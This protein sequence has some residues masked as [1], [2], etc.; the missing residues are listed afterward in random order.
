MHHCFRVLLLLI[1]SLILSGS[2]IISGA[3]EQ[4]KFAEQGSVDFVVSDSSDGK[5]TPCRIHIVD[6]AGKPVRPT[7]LTL[8]YWKDHFV[9]EGTATVKLPPGDY[10][11]EVER[12]R[13]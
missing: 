5:Y 2:N 6:A 3:A 9:C 13:E 1:A 8:P 11:Y 10:R 7:G 12:G 4:H